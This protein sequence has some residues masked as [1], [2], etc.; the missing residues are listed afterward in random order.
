MSTLYTSTRTKLG[1]RSLRPRRESFFTAMGFGR[2]NYLTDTV[3]L[4]AAAAVSR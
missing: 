4:P 1:Y 3:L 2:L